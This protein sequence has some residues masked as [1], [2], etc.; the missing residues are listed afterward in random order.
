MP[1]E[2]QTQV[3]QTKTLENCVACCSTSFFP[4][5][6]WSSSICYPML[7]PP[8]LKTNNYWCF[9]PPPLPSQAQSERGC[10]QWWQRSA[11]WSWDW[12]YR[13]PAFSG[14]SLTSPSSSVWF[15]WS[16]FLLFL[17][18]WR[19]Y[20]NKET[21]N[22]E[23]GTK[24]DEYPQGFLGF[25]LRDESISASVGHLYYYYLWF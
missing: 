24:E 19:Y 21:R 15:S 13:Y 5:K 10:W 16:L 1:S 7:W 6:L 22:N 9:L 2:T 14:A 3:N 8:G 23:T 18:Y 17:Q 11:S 20:N 25:K 4:S 12:L